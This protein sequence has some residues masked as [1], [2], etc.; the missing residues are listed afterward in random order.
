MTDAMFQS[1]EVLDGY[2]AAVS[3]G[4]DQRQET[5]RVSKAD[6]DELVRGLLV[7]GQHFMVL[8]KAAARL[9]AEKKA[10]SEAD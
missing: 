3:D 10:A 6:R 4:L 7:L 2:V 1:P 9:E 8:A 5:G